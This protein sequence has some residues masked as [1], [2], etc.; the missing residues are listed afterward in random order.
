MDPTVESESP[1]YYLKFSETASAVTMNR[2]LP[3]DR[4][5]QANFLLISTENHMIRIES[6]V[7]LYTNNMIPP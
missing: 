5:P 1:V 3:I 4:L 6:N 7:L 2:K